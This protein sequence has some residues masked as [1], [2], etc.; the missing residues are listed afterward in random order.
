M[1]INLQ[2]LI[3]ENTIETLFIFLFREAFFEAEI[4]ELF[5]QCYQLE[6]QLRKRLIM[7]QNCCYN[8]PLI[9]KCFFPNQ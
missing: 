4:K 1:N 2:A 6:L 5:D 3:K 8:Q 7:P 9:T